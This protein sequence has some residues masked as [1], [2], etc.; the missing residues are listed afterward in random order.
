MVHRRRLAGAVATGV[1]LAAL[2]PA[3]AAENRPQAMAILDAFKAASGGGAWDRLRTLHVRS[4][5]SGADLTGT[6]DT[7]LDMAH[8]W[9]ATSSNLGPERSGDGFNGKLIWHT[10][11]AGQVQIEGS[12][13]QRVADISEAYRTAHGYWFP[14]RFAAAIDYTGAVEDGNTT[15]DVLTI[16]PSGGRAFKLFI[17]RLTH[18]P[19]KMVEP[20][21]LGTQ[22]ETY[23][24]W[25]RVSGATLPFRVETTTNDQG[26]GGTTATVR[27]V[28]AS[29][30]AAPARY[31][32]PPP[33]PP[34]FSLPQGKLSVTLPFELENNHI[35]VEALVD[36]AP[37]RLMFDT[38]STG[39]LDTNALA[40][41][42]LSAQGALAAQGSGAKIERSGLVRL[43]RLDL[44]GIVFRDQIV[45][46]LDESSF[47][48]VEGG[49]VDGV[50]GYE[51]VKRLVVEIDYGA[52]RLTLFTRGSFHPAPG[53][54]A[55]P[56]KFFAQIP[57]ISAQVDGIEGEFVIDTGSRASLLLLKPFVERNDLQHRYDAHREG[58]L[59]WSIGGPVRGLLARAGTLEI[60][61][62]RFD[63]PVVLI[64]ERGPPVDGNI[65]GGI[66]RHFDVAFDYAHDRIW[67]R[68]LSSPPDVYDRSGLWANQGPAG[69][70]IADVLPDSPA[71]DADLAA[72]DVIQAIDGLTV[73]AL[74][75]VTVRA[76]LKQAPGTH[77]Q[78]TILRNGTSRAV[79]LALRDLV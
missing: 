26:I 56:I 63:R 65:G 37:A 71:S 39:F 28:I 32:P 9:F 79:D 35:Y 59:G 3:G 42:G 45:G 76:R 55:V 36:G 6:A 50:L 21:P 25:H 48:A 70:T 30:A 47:A 46:T 75:L 7:W 1:L 20:A 4:N 17:D 60:G 16:T 34:D 64:P 24:D 66:L 13:D 77:V 31:A 58:L 14:K 52:K 38:G 33:P 22:T 10:D 73:P 57:E 23:G 18:L 29:K 53:A 51:I 27:T 5:L 78:L 49:R 15:L 19:R 69:I 44:G 72:G 41:L 2:P 11:S 54:I 74:D 61:G 43:G 12:A 8:G 67:F 62:V 40:R 68:P